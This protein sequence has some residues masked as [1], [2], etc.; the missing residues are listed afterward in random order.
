MAKTILVV[1]DN[2]MNQQLMVALL[3]HYGYEVIQ[4]E[5]GAEA[6]S[7]ANSQHV[8]LIMMDMQMPIMNG[9]EAIKALRQ[10]ERTSAIKILVITS[11]ALNDEKQKILDTG[12]NGFMVKPI[13][14][15]ELP[16]IVAQMLEKET[17]QTWKTE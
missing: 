3:G 17:Q 1:E 12:V 7:I 6:L 9:Y 4:A 5:N 15:R 2:Q 8:D 13:D 16:R 14:T 11:F 10:D